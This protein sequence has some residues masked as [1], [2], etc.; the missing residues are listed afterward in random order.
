MRSLSGVD[1]PAPNGSGTEGSRVRA[2]RRAQA[3]FLANHI[4]SRQTANPVERII[5]V[6]DFNAFNV[7]DGYVD[8][9]GTI[10]GTPAPADQV[11]LASSDLVNPDQTNLVDT[12]PADQRYSFTFDGN[13]QTLDH[14]IVNPNALSLLN[15]FAF[16]RNDADFP[17]K[18]Y[19]DPARP[20][21]LSDH[22]MPVA[23]L[24]LGT[25]LVISEFRFRSPTFSAPQGLD[26]SLDEYIELYN[27]SAA[28][29]TVNAVDGSAGWALAYLNG[30][31]N[32]QTVAAVIPNGTIIPANGHY[33]LTNEA[34]GVAAPK[35]AV[36]I[37]PNGI[38][39]TGGYTLTNYAPG[40]LTYRTTPGNTT[41]DIPD[42]GAI[43]IFQTA[44]SANF[45]TANRLDAVSLNAATGALADLYR[46]GTNLPS[47]GANDGQYA[48]VRKLTTGV[49]Q[50]TDNNAQDFVFV[51]T[52]GGSYGGVQSQLGAPG[53]ESTISPIQRNATIK[54]TLIEP[55]A[56]ANV[57]PNRV[58][59]LTAVTNGAQGTLSIRRRFTNM[60]GQ[61][62]TRLRFRVVDITT[63]NSPG[64]TPGGSQSDVRAIDGANFSITTSRGPLTVLGTTIEQPPPLAQPNGGGLNTSLTVAI[65][66]GTLAPGAPIDL[67]FLLGV[68]QGGSYRFFINVEALP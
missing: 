5:N 27:N 34:G 54:A 50:D 9:I 42:N 14:I 44:N 58:R 22:D 32:T 36:H 59:S 52:N 17:V 53:P 4:Q 49:P 35:L 39:P 56:S 47:P 68:Q 15:R 18:Y 21:R 55:Q 40:D 7:N 60:T 29:V 26:G 3:E 12:L 19:Q 67:H 11:V 48:Y 25:P 41:I 16:A 64:Y 30:A 13:A 57:A 31:G 33:L 24:T 45:S 62:V 37:K 28:P 2:K 10:K 46:E 6:G 63:L 65:P 23:Y 38:T 43:A 66:G 1:D 8:V 61:M 20:E 51:S